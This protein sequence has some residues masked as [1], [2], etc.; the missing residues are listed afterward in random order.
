MPQ[1][2]WSDKRERQF[3][4]IKESEM[5]RGRS[6]EDA[7]EIAARVVNKQRRQNGETS[8]RTTQGTGNPKQSLEE[9][10]KQELYNRARQLHIKGRSKMT[11]RELVAAIRLRQ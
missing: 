7:E 1:Q 10:S 9:R 6:E 4:H 5:N 11:K 3:Q 2:I 8:N